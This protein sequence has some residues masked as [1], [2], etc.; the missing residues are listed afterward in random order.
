MRGLFGLAALAM[1]AMV[2]FAIWAVVGLIAFYLVTLFAIW[3]LGVCFLR[4]WRRCIDSQGGARMAY[5]V[6]LVLFLSAVG[7]VGSYLHQ[8]YNLYQNTSVQHRSSRVEDPWSVGEAKGGGETPASRNLDSPAPPEHTGP[9]QVSSTAPL[10]AAPEQADPMLGSSTWPIAQ[11]PGME[12]RAARQ[13][14]VWY[15]FAQEPQGRTD[16]RPGPDNFASQPRIARQA[17]Q[18][19]YGVWHKFTPEPQP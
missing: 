18:R 7:V 13:Y 2:I 8:G 9:M 10:A 5:V 15:K 16:A 17:T 11:E 6:L 14:G 12:G 3:A 4:L 19:R 1:A